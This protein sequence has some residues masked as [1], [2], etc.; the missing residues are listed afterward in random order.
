MSKHTPGPWFIDH[1]TRPA[2]VCTIH[3]TSHPNGYVY[4][5]GEIGYWDADGDENMANARLI[6]AAPDFYAM[7]EMVLAWWDKHKDDTTDYV[8]D[9]DVFMSE[10]AFVTAASAA[11]AKATG[12]PT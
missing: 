11:I 4:V 2:E 8:G 10:P 9:C 1:E 6:A 12:E 3:H 5:R 7:A